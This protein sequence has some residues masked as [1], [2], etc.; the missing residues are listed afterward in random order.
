MKFLFMAAGFFLLF[1]FQNCLKTNLSV[2]K[3]SSNGKVNTTGSGSEIS[4]VYLKDERVEKVVFN[5]TGMGTTIVNSRPISLNGIYSYDINLETAVVLRLFNQN[6]Q[7]VFLHCLPLEEL[8]NLKNILDQS[9]IC[10]IKN[11]VPEGQVC[12]MMYSLGYALIKTQSGEYDLGSASDGC[13][14]L[15]IKF[16]DQQSE[17]AAKNWFENFRTNV[18][19]NPS[20]Y[21]CP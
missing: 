2:D 12:T 20:Q 19:T 16:C 13:A 18:T 9:A 1:N 4:R 8:N 5:A 10:K 21:Q 15:Q 17:A 11:E 6:Q 14:S 7:D 3:N